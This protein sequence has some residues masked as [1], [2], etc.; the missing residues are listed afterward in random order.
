MGPA[1]I[2][3]MFQ[4][5]RV[6]GWVVSAVLQVFVDGSQGTLCRVDQPTR[7]SGRYIY[8]GPACIVD[9][10]QWARVQGWV[11]IAAVQGLERSQGRGE[12]SASSISRHGSV[13]ARA[14][15]GG[16]C[17]AGYRA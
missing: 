3:D 12:D 10:F 7:L 14:G 8:M 1:C 6:Q 16:E 13:G 9:M 17:C 15:L 5:A 11:V 2:V 4:W